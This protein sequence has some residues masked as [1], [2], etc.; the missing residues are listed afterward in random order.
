LVD[1]DAITVDPEQAAGYHNRSTKQM[2][3]RWADAHGGE[4]V[5]KEASKFLAAAGLFHDARQA[6]GALFAAAGRMPEF[7]RVGRGI[8]R[9]KLQLPTPNVSRVVAPPPAQIREHLDTRSPTADDWLTHRG[10]SGS[11]ARQAATA[12]EAR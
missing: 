12:G 9:R 5:M 6:A 10:L 11:F 1:P 4:V 8:F 2:L 3:E 7:E